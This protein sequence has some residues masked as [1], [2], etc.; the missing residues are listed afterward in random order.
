MDPLRIHAYKIHAIKR[1]KRQKF[2]GTI[3]LYSIST[4]A[5]TLLCSSPLWYPPFCATF[6]V[7]F[8][9]ALPKICSFFFTSK[10]LFVVGNLIVIFLVGESKFFRSKSKANSHASYSDICYDKYKCKSPKPQVLAKR[11]KEKAMGITLSTNDAKTS[12]DEKKLER[13]G[14]EDISK[15]GRRG[16]VRRVEELIKYEDLEVNLGAEELNK[17]A[18]DFI[19]R[20]NRQRRLEAE[21]SM[22][23]LNGSSWNACIQDSN[24]QEAQKAEVC[25]QCSPILFVNIGLYTVLFGPIW[26][27]PFSA[28]FNVI[29]FVS[30]PRII[31]F[32]FS[33]KVL[34]VVGNFIVIFLLGEWKLFT[35]WS[36]AS[37]ASYFDIYYDMYKCKI[38]DRE[39]FAR[40]S[41]KAIKAYDEVISYE[42]NS[43]KSNGGDPE[44]KVVD[45]DVVNLSSYE[46]KKLADDFIARI[47]TQ[48]RLEEA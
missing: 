1:H 14:D 40:S 28:T 18:D 37:G 10:V 11:G 21:F 12:F 8:F 24:H 3:L 48:R 36:K 44:E 20:I 16:E 47:H 43:L 23:N 35:S 6:N 41:H 22:E 34:F 46:L 4:L 27:P 7:I 17:L 32:L 5:C 42:E 45:L 33:S 29:F 31:S 25:E 2:M 30:V 39:V 26:Y 9:F 13:K 15:S 19:A 38:S